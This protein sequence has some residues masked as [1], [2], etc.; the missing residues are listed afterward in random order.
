MTKKGRE[1]PGREARHGGQAGRLLHVL[2]FLIERFFHIVAFVVIA[3]FR[4]FV[5]V[6]I[7][8]DDVDVHRVDLDNLQLSLAAGAVQDLALLHFVFVHV[9][10]D[11]AF[12]AANQSRNLLGAGWRSLQASV[13]YT[14]VG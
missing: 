1:I 8:G 4:L 2:F 11:S 14:G 6:I 13:L 3:F 10:F 12:G 7:F 9:D 5:I